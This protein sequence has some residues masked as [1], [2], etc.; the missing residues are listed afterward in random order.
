MRRS[1]A[2]WLIV[3]ALLGGSAAGCTDDDPAPAPTTTTTTG[4]GPSTSLAPPSGEDPALEAMALTETDLPPGFEPSTDV[5]DTITSFC[6]NE[7]AAAGLR[8]TGRTVRGFTRAAGGASVIQ[9]AFRFEAGGAA[10]FVTQ[11]GQILERC[12]GVPDG[13]GLA[14]EY[15]PLTP[16]LDA[17]LTAGADAHTGRYG[18]SVGSGNLTVDLVAFARGDVAQLV[19]VLGLEAPRA[20]LDALATTVFRA[21]LAKG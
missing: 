11:A 16:E 12:S 1:T 17:L 9:L 10:T 3:A 14:F 13:T 18:T 2:T 21:A 7:D 4:G 15:E 19:A 6:A 20:D 5:D 8:A